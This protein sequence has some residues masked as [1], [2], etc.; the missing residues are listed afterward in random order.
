MLLSEISHSP[1]LGPKVARWLDENEAKLRKHPALQSR[2][3][4]GSLREEAPPASRAALTD[5][6]RAL[7]GRMATKEVPCFTTKGLPQGSVPE[8]DRQLAGQEMGIN[9]MTVDEYLMGR[10]AFEDGS[11]ARD[12]KVARAA[13]AL[14]SEQLKQGLLE[15]FRM[16]GL[17]PREAE[18]QA[19]AQ[20]AEKMAALAALHN[21]DMVAGGKDAIG[22]F[23][24]RKIN[25][26]IGAQWKKSQRLAQLDKAATA[27]AALGRSSIKMSVKLVRCK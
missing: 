16:Q 25:S 4:A 23:G 9:S 2:A 27:I 6:E 18:E 24:D 19:I 20:A 12:P 1:R 3:K 17:S 7:A 26:R 13:R 11:T 15:E 22:D 8:F 21:P 14:Y 10:Q 5:E